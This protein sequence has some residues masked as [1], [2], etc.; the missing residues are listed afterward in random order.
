MVGVGAGAAQL[1]APAWTPAGPPWKTEE[2]TTLQENTAARPLA[3]PDPDPDPDPGPGQDPLLT[4]TLCFQSS[5]TARG[6]GTGPGCGAGVLS[7]LPCGESALQAGVLRSPPTW[8]PSGGAPAESHQHDDQGPG[9]PPG[10]PHRLL[11]PA[12]P[13]SQDEITSSAPQKTLSLH[14]TLISRPEVV[15]VGGW[16]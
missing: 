12:P 5:L 15:V 7:P 9:R 6:V 2:P 16:W 11:T 8:L 1:P 13:C 4:S 14:K 10:V 3:R